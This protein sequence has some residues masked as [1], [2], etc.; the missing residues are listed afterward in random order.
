MCIRD[1]YKYAKDFIADLKTI[2]AGLHSIGA[3]N[4]SEKLVRPLRWQASVFGFSAHTLDVRQ[5]SEVVT[6]VLANIWST[7]GTLSEPGSE[8]WLKQIKTELV[9]P[10]LSELDKSKLTEESLELISLL[11]LILTVQNGPDPEAVGP[12]ILS[13]TRSAAD[14]L[15]VLLL[16]RMLV[17]GRKNYL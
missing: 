16:A 13:M 6:R 15:S 12:F 8:S 1:R 3:V 4:I 17:L 5:N 9:Q 2:E 14:I 11:E 10:N 7:L